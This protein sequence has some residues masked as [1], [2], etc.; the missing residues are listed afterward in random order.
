MPTTHRGY[1]PLTI[2]TALLDACPKPVQQAYKPV[3]VAQE[4]VREARAKLPDLEAAA[5]VAPEVDERA[6]LQ[7][8]VD[9]TPV[10]PVTAQAARDAV[11]A[12]KREIKAVETVADDVEREFLLALV[13]AQPEIEQ[14]IRPVLTAQVD[15]ARQAIAAFLDAAES[16]ALVS[17]I[18]GW[19][20]RRDDSVPRTLG[21]PLTM[22]FDGTEQTLDSW[23]DRIVSVVTRRDPDEVEAREAAH[24]ALVAQQSGQRNVGGLVLDRAGSKA[25]HG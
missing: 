10:P 21:L 22:V 15:A 8:V 4:R 7:A 16:V 9:G 25:V 3:P 23:C 20:R 19:A 5:R 12:C 13:D 11:D 2:P 17:A 6:A 18:W 24:A 1:Y 14:A